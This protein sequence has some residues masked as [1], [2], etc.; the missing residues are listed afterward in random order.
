M[1]LQENVDRWPETVPMLPDGGLVKSVN[2][3]SKLREAKQVWTAA[4]RDPRKLLTCFRFNDLEECPDTDWNG[5]LAHARRQ[6]FRFVDKTYLENYLPYIDRV[7]ECNEYTATSTW[8]DP[9]RTRIVTESARAYAVVWNTEFRGK[10]VHSPDGGEGR[11]PDTCKL[12]LCNGPVSNWIHRNYFELARAED[13]ALGYHPYVKCVQ[14]V[15]V[16]EDWAQHSGLQHVMEEAFGIFVEWVYTEGGPY[17]H[18]SEGWRHSLCLGGDVG[19]LVGFMREW[20]RQEVA[21]RAAREGRSHTPAMFTSKEDTHWAWYR[22]EYPEL[23][24]LNEM[25][26]QEWKPAPPPPT[27][28]IDVNVEDIR[29][30]RKDALEIISICDKYDP[31]AP[32]PWW[33][34]VTP[35][36]VVIATSLPLTTYKAPGG[37]IHD[38]RPNATYDLNVSERQGEWLKVAPLPLWVKVQ[39]VKLKS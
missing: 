22:Y 30:I 39:D 15:R 21:T 5:K 26:A 24:L 19:K 34:N 23:K 17:Y 12:V 25:F 16:S 27:G 2:D 10:V 14:G 29:L 38:V 1:H 8:T 36:Y 31:P 20:T 7:E 33:E 6:F 28:D 11:I 13:C 18:T 4:G 32:T 9:N 35:P 3:P 37:E